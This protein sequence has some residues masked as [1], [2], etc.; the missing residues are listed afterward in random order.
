VESVT[1]AAG[2]PPIIT[3]AEPLT[4]VS[5]PQLSPSVAAGMPPISTVGVPGGMIGT[6]EPW[7]ATLTRLSVTRAAGNTSSSSS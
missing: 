4:M 2:L 7:V 1:R 3:V 5:A 6:G